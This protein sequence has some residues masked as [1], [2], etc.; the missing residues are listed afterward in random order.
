MQLVPYLDLTKRAVDFRQPTY[1]K[2]S[3]TTDMLK[4][5]FEDRIILKGQ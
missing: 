1:L 4:E 5:F 3:T 2:T